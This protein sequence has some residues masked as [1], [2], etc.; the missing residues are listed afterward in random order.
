MIIHNPILTGSFTVN[1]TDVASITSSAASITAINS[2]TASQN[3]LNGTYAT[4][5]S[6]TF[7]NPQ[8]INS[9]L[10]VT[11]S[12]TAATLVVQTITSSVIYSSGSNVFGNSQANTQVMTGSVNI[13]GSVA[14]ASA[15]TYALDV[16]GTGRFT[17]KLTVNNAASA[18]TLLVYGGN[19]IDP[20]TDSAAGE[21]RIGNNASYYGNIAYS[22]GGSTQL[23]IDNSYDNAAASMVFRMR[24]LGTPINALTILG[25]GAATFSSSVC[26]NGATATSDLN[27]YNSS[28]PKITFQNS[29]ANRAYIY[30]D[31]SYLYLNSVTSNPITI[32]I[33]SSE[34][35]RITSGGQINIGSSTGDKIIQFQTDASTNYVAKIL[36]NND[37]DYIQFSGGSAANRTNGAFLQL[38]G[39]NRYGT[40]QGGQVSLVAGSST[41]N[42]AYGFIGFETGTSERMRI[43]SN[44]CIGIGGVYDTGIQLMIQSQTNSSTSYIIYGRNSTPAVQFYVRSDAYGYLNDTAWHYGSDLRMKENI[45]DILEGLSIISEL[46]PKHFDYIDGAK[47]R[48]GFIAQ[49]VQNILPNL[50]SISN[51]ETGMLALQTD[52]LIPYLVKAI[53]EL[54]AQIT[55]LKN[56]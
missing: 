42:S 47:N 18:F 52:A 9:N 30:A 6:N 14:I 55:E 40:G 45:S 44:G 10:I 35:M 4:T 23:T 54:Q 22:N 37:V 28:Q 24:T 19:S 16:T 36:M 20:R 43:L 31:S 1:G 17:G 21:I 41:N 8:T 46:K 32:Q 29:S 34:K 15:A 53:Q 51:E 38:V 49:E 26:V 2:Y 48:I 27:I 39:N 25:T 33:D 50:V 13:T 3:I 56:K 5:G 7:K 11:G 12:I